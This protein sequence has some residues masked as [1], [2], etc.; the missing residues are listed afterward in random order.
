MIKEPSRERCLF[1][2]LAFS[3]TPSM[4]S[5][6][7]DKSSTAFTLTN[8]DQMLSRLSQGITRRSFWRV[9]IIAPTTVAPLF[10]F[11]SY[12]NTKPAGFTFHIDSPIND[13]MVWYDRGT[14]YRS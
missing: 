6:M 14:F 1:L 5:T 2:S 7:A 8:A 13:T 4:L 3:G 9:L 12:R 10:S 11:I